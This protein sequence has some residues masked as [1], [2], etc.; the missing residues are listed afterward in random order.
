MSEKFQNHELK[1][2]QPQPLFFLI[3]SPS[4]GYFIILMK[5]HTKANTDKHLH[6]RPY[7]KVKMLSSSE[8]KDIA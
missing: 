7:L 5:K 3:K 6:L 4:L 8:L 1:K 2:Q